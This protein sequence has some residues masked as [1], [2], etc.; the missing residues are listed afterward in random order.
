MKIAT[1]EITKNRSKTG[2]A[3]TASSASSRPAKPRRTSK[4]STSQLVRQK[5]GEPLTQ[6]DLDLVEKLLAQPNR[7]INLKD[8][9]ETTENTFANRSGIL[10]AGLF[11]PYKL[12][13]TLRIDAD[14]IAWAR[15]GGE[16]YQ[17]RINS[18][19]RKAMLDDLKANGAKSC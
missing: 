6:H 3:S 8:I 4:A 2:P 5:W 15:R 10:A 12:Q 18:A 7:E 17:T 13:V 1:P 19:L 9:P 14:I 16:G 11:K